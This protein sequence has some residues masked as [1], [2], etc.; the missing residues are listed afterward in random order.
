[1]L[2]TLLKPSSP[3][4]DA[5]SQISLLVLLIAIL[6]FAVVA[7]L[8]TWATFKYRERPGRTAPQSTG[9]NKIEVLWTI[10]PVIILVVVFFFT[11]KTMH[12]VDPP[13]GDTNADIII[14][15]HQWWWEVKYP[16]SGVITANE[17]H[18]PVG[19]RMLVR[20]ESADV[21]HDFWVPQLARKID[22]IPGRSNYLYLEA[23]SPGSY[24]G[25]C[26]E[27]CGTQ[28]AGMRILVIAQAPA[29]FTKWETAQVAPPSP[30][31]DP[32]AALGAKIFEDKTCYFCHTVA[33]TG[34]T[35]TIGPDLTYVATRQ[36]L[37]AGVLKNSSK[38]LAAWLKNPQLFKPGSHMP[39][40]Q[41]SEHEVQALVSYLESLP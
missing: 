41:L 20:L 6:I 24:R 3:Q 40:F 26:A 21:I 22:A 18:I 10:P 34:S 33:G 37:G 31:S 27:Y 19:K 2:L 5:L 9:N 1:M 28:H 30:A 7:A 13:S 15:G 29:E 12:A 35:E 14:T 4:A 38:N 39:D 16:A 17:I 8:V 25:V 23:D 36:T 32:L 11:V